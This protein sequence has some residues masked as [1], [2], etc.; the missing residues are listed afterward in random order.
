MQQAQGIMGESAEF[1][2][3]FLYESIVLTCLHTHVTTV[4]KYHVCVH[5]HAD[6][7]PL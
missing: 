6:S 5:V 7:Y 4:T 3:H 2:P 1:A